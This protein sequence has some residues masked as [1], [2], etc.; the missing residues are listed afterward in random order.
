MKRT[1]RLLFA[2]EI[3]HFVS[4]FE[5]YPRDFYNIIRYYTRLLTE[6]ENHLSPE[7]LTAAKGGAEKRDLESTLEELLDL[8]DQ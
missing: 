3:A 5:D 6:L 4:I 8:L 1:A 7:E 2:G